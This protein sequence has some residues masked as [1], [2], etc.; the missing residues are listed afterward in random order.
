MA[1]SSSVVLSI[2]RRSPREILAWNLLLVRE[3]LLFFALL[4]LEGG[5]RLSSNARLDLGRLLRQWVGAL[6][7]PSGR[8]SCRSADLLAAA[9]ASARSLTGARWRKGS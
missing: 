3:R 9:R 5:R 8:T 6:R 4:R 2:P 7:G 1:Q